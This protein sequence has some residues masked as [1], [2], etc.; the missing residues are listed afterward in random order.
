MTTKATK[1]WSVLLIDDE[2]SLLDKLSNEVRER[3]DP[4]GVEVRT[5]L[6]KKE[7]SNAQDTFDATV[8]SNTLLVVTDYDLSKGQKGLF[9][10]S[11]VAWSQAKAVPVGDYS[12]GKPAAL[13]SEPN[14]FELRVP[15]VEGKAAAFIAAVCEGFKEVREATKEN[16]FGDKRN[17]AAVIA[18]IVEKPELERQ[19]ALFTARLG[20]ANAG[21]VEKL[22][23]TAGKDASP[24][25]QQRSE[26]LAYVVGHVLLNAV[27]KFA[28]PV[29]SEPALSSYVAIRA[30]Q[31]SVVAPLLEKAVYS[32]P[33]RSVEKYYW[34]DSIDEILA[35][36]ADGL[37]EQTFE[38]VG[39]MNRAA[40]ERMLGKSLERHGCDRCN[41][42]NGGYHCPFTQRTVC[43]RADCSVTASSWIPQGA[44]VCRVEKDFYDEWAPLL[45]L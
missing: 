43:Q 7:E 37:D 25:A 24:D 1:N 30:D 42:N 39:E 3:V 29:L 20:A 44:D 38:T 21:L 15:I 9:G 33:F 36:A 16:K 35:G 5:W 4:M 22:R 23:A 2:Q 26:L 27:L 45:G 28:G 10:V 32:G 18:A 6:P 31:L 41:G 8:D 19:F 40:L 34:R 11:I 13:P 17:P 12:R 14:F